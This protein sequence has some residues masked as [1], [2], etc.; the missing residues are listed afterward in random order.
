MRP[1]TRPWSDRRSGVRDRSA[2]L[3]NINRGAEPLLDDSD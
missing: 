3:V 1:V 2:E